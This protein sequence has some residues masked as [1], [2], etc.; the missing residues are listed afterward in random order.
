MIVASL[1][2]FVGLESDTK[3]STDPD[4]LPSEIVSTQPAPGTL[5]KPQ[6]SVSA[7]LR[8][9]LTGVLIIDGV[10]IPEDQLGRPTQN[11]MVFQ[12]GPDKEFSRFSTGPHLVQV[13]FWP[14]IRSRDDAE[15]Y[16]FGFRTTA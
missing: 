10:E 9:D 16:T 13:V 4:A 1:V 6:Q 7:V 3:S 12:P 11:S 5:N 8:D 14:S 2:V 15:T